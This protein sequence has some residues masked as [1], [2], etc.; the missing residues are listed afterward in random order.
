MAAARSS[1]VALDRHYSRLR[2]TALFTVI[3]AVFVAVLT[4]LSAHADRIADQRAEADRVYNELQAARAKTAGLDQRVQ[5]AEE[6]LAAITTQVRD[7]NVRLRVVKHNL[8]YAR[9]SLRASIAQEYQNP[10]LD[11][12]A[13]VLS[14]RSLGQVL[15]DVALLRRTTHRGA[16][17][18]RDVR[19]AQ[20]DVA[21]VQLGLEATQTRR[22]AATDEVHRLRRELNSAIAADKN[23]LLG[24]KRSIR[25]LLQ[26]RKDAERAAAA[27]RA[28]EAAS[29]L[30]RAS[31]VT[32]QTNDI[33]LTGGA[34]AGA[35]GPAPLPSVSGSDAASFALSKQGSPYVY[36]SEG[37]NTFDCSGL[38]MWAY[39]QVGITLGRTTYDQRNNGTHVGPPYARGDLLFF[40]GYSHM[41]MALGNGQM[42]E[43]PHTGDVVKVV[44]LATYSPVID[45]V[46]VT[47]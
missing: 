42:V 16:V 21:G 19:R 40:D 41:G 35:S 10:K 30:Q 15:D 31:A 27:R 44:D 4:P 26:Q 5:Y 3:C 32:V 23:R 33:G 17:V 22:Q 34:A 9:S 13:V 12:L 46:R 45:A 36:G 38:T 18:L 8:A 29:A 2:P 25:V 39:A 20:R 11:P 28:Q 37:P 1:E 7:N 24:L 14:A 6:Q 47:G 43:A